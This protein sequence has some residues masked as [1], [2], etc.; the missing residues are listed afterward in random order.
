[1]EITFDDPAQ[2]KLFNDKKAELT[3]V[4]SKLPKKINCMTM[5]FDGLKYFVVPNKPTF[6][7]RP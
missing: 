4:K 2:S 3:V 6:F 1:M 5:E 7:E